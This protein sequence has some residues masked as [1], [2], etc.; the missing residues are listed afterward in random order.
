[1]LVTTCSRSSRLSG[2]E[3]LRSASI[4]ARHDRGAHPEQWKEE[5]LALEDRQGASRYYFF[6]FFSERVFVRH[7]F[8][9]YVRQ[10]TTPEN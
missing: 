8:N 1:M 5:R 10:N 2:C 3:K 6:F 9:V 7:F 4:P